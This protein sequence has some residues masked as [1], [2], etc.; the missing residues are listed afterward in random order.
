MK[1]YMGIDTSCY[2][3]SVAILDE[4]GKLLSDSRKFLEVKSGNRGLAQSEMVFQHTR[5]LPEVFA[6]AVENL[7]KPLPL[8]A[9]GV[10]AC[11]RSLPDSYM[12]AFLAGDG[13]A[14]TL[15]MAYGNRLCRL[16]HQ[17][18]H[19]YAGIWSAGGPYE[20]EFLAV[21]ASG[22]TTEIVKVKQTPCSLKVS[23]LGET[24]DL[25]AGQF[26]DRVGV[27]MGLPFPA[28]RHLEMLAGQEEG[29]DIPFSVKEMNVSFSGPA[30]HALR[31]LHAEESKAGI[32]AGVQLCIGRTLT[33]LIKNAV[34]Y[35]GLSHVLLVGGVL[36]NEFVREYLRQN[37]D[38]AELTL[39]FP[40]KEFNPDNGIGPA[41]FAL[42]SGNLR[43]TSAYDT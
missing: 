42:R 16:S 6:K 3:T 2:T 10:T 38:Q 1:L 9:I 13:C 37:L 22:G 12:P 5:N 7:P 30:T 40:R 43:G 31:L 24:L 25:N 20:E 17:E 15:S 8:T 35:S 11:P 23:M 32:A 29:V 27:A 19:I 36:S 33:K 41:Y 34:R 39:Y 28:G 26:I 14:R 4:A 18:G 21:H